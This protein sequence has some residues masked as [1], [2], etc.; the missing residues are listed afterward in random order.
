MNFLTFRLWYRANGKLSAREYVAL[1]QLAKLHTRELVEY[2]NK[3]Y[4]ANY[5]PQK[6][7]KLRDR[8]SLAYLVR[9]LCDLL[10]T[11]GVI[12]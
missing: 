10:Y 1:M 12:V 3:L 7:R 11:L 2:F 4:K 5:T 9:T 6:A 8:F